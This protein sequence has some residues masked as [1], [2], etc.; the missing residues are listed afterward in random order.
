MPVF[1]LSSAAVQEQIQIANGILKIKTITGITE[2]VNGTTLNTLT[3]MPTT[4]QIP[5]QIITST[6]WDT[7][8]ASTSELCMAHARRM[9]WQ[10]KMVMV[11]TLY[12]HMGGADQYSMKM[13]ETT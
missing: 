2:L 11:I 4:C 10:D 12:I 6:G 13:E 5:T 3:S 9:Q 1:T 8:Q 7:T